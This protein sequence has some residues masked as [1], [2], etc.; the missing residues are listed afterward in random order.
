MLPHSYILEN[1]ERKL[2][3]AL[4]TLHVLEIMSLGCS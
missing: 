3:I 4:C 2:G 1:E